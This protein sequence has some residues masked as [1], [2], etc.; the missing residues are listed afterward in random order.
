MQSFNTSFPPDE[1]AMVPFNAKSPDLTSLVYLGLLAAFSL[2]TMVLNNKN[3]HQDFK[4]ELDLAKQHIDLLENDIEDY[5]KIITELTISSDILD[6]F[7]F[8]ALIETEEPLSAKMILTY[9]QNETQEYTKKNINSRLYTL[10]HKNI[11]K[12]SNDKTPLWSLV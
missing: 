7:I 3:N 4:I 9:V 6:D 5:K 1:M 10:L 12:K 11:V 2:Q 8:S